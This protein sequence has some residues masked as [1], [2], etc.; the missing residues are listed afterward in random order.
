MVDGDKI[1]VGCGFE[2]LVAD[3]IG[4][5][6]IG[7]EIVANG[8]GVEIGVSVD[9]AIDSALEAFPSSNRLPPRPP[10]RS[11]ATIPHTQ[12]G[13]FFAVEEAIST[14]TGVNNTGG[15][16]SLL[17]LSK[18]VVC[19]EGGG[20]SSVAISVSWAGVREARFGVLAADPV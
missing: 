7:L 16:H 12:K 1:F 19:P 2:V 5:F 15:F 17:S 10:I 6:A 18:T 14:V 4:A 3:V 13:I 20:S 11:I 9:E 8:K